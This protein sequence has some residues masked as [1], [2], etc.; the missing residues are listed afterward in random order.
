MNTY[1]VKIGRSAQT[2]FDTLIVRATSVSN[3]EKKVNQKRKELMRDG[4]KP[5]RVLSVVEL[6]GDFVD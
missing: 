5:L 1:Q 4:D 2:P 3:A 6:I